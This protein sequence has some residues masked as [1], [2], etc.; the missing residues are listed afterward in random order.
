MKTTKLQPQTTPKAPQWVSASRVKEALE[1]V[2]QS[3]LMMEGFGYILDE[4]NSDF[5]DETDHDN[6]EE[7][8]RKALGVA[9]IFAADRMR[10]AGEFL[11]EIVKKSE[12]PKSAGHQ[13][14]A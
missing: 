12:G 5:A 3:A 13:A 4:Y 9:C 1:T 2:Y 8:A 11:G 14:A 6:R 7:T 10:D